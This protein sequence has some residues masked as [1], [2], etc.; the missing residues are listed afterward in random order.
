V[1]K[2]GYKGT[3]QYMQETVKNWYPNEYEKITGIKVTKDES[4]TR[5]KQ[6]EHNKELQFRSQHAHDYISSRAI[7]TSQETWMPEQTVIVEAQQPNT[8]DT[9]LYLIPTYDNT[10][11][12]IINTS[13]HLD[14]TEVMNIKT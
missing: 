7:D 3:Q 4:I 14:V 2:Y 13:H 12:T 10:K 5:R 11:N 8:G 1:E 9:R 6:I